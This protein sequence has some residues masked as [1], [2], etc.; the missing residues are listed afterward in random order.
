MR[1]RE[2]TLRF[3][4][5]RLET[6]RVGADEIARSAAEVSGIVQSFLLKQLGRD[7]PPAQR[8]A[9]EEAQQAVRANLEEMRRI[10]QELRPEALDHLGLASALNNLARAFAR[11]T[12]ITVDRRIDPQLGQLD[13]NVELVLYRVAQEALSNALR[14]S[15]ARRVVTAYHMPSVMTSANAF[16]VQSS[17]KS[18]RSLICGASGG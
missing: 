2:L 10:A 1:A 5:V 12:S 16:S 11:R 9:L 13:R 7:A 6:F 4:G 8:D 15:G 14:H 18:A 3:D 17:R